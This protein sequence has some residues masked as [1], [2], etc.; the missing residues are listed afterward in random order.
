MSLD[1]ENPH[2]SRVHPTQRIVFVDY[3]AIAP[4]NQEELAVT[5]EVKGLGRQLLSFA[6]EVARQLGYEGGFGL[7]STPEAAATYEGGFKLWKGTME[8]VPDDGTWLYFEGDGAWLERSR[9]GRGKP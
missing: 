6:V 2:W 9:G 8:A 5:R 4:W 3:V 1:G 7:H